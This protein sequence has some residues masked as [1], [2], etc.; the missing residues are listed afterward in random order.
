MSASCA[1]DFFC[2]ITAVLSHMFTFR[3][4]MAGEKKD[5]GDT[6]W[7]YNQNTENNKVRKT[8]DKTNIL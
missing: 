8:F 5:G 7:M 1:S 2:D 3:N 6:D 4:K